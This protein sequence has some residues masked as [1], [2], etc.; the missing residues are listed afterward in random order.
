[1]IVHALRSFIFYVI[2]FPITIMLV[3][4]S[5]FF[6]TLSDMLRGDKEQR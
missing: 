2:V 3:A 1:M 5:A 4:A 6:L